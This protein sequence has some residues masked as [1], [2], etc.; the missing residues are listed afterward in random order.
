MRESNF[1]TKTIAIVAFLAVMVYF[2]TRL[3]GYLVDPLTTTAAYYY[4]SDDAVTVSGYVIRQEELLPD[5]SGL[6][7]STRQEGERVGKGRS[8]ATV[9]HSEAALSDARQLEILEE[10]L[11]QLQ[12]AQSAASGAQAMLKLDNS[13]RGEI[14]RASC[15]ERV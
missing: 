6:V 7:Y 3:G 2:A 9:Y 15:R 11:E 13:I 14:G 4:E 5:H 12:Y 1:V 10:R 8:V